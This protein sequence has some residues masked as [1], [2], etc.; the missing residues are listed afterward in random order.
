MSMQKLDFTVLE[1]AHKTATGGDLVP[2]YAIDARLVASLQEQIRQQHAVIASSGKALQYVLARIEQKT[3]LMCL[4]YLTEPHDR[5]ITSLAQIMRE[6]RKE[7]AARFKAHH[8]FRQDYGCI[9]DPK[10]E[11]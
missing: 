3:E 2:L 7:I 4:F 8:D 10:E 11:A 1:A 6:P 9:D 5:M